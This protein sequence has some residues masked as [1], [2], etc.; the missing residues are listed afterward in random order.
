MIAG[1]IVCARDKRTGQRSEF[2]YAP[3]LHSMALRFA[4]ELRMTNH[5]VTIK[6]QRIATA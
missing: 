3:E 5:T 4:A 6:V 2:W 1:Y